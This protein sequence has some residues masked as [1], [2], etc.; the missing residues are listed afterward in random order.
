M[1]SATSG[2]VRGAFRQG[3]DAADL[4][5]EERKKG[6]RGLQIEEEENKGR[7]GPNET[8]TEGRCDATERGEERAERNYD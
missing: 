3:R 6:E 4:G 5:S 1:T 7:I 2:R 8:M